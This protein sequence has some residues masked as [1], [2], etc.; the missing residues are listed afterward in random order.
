M[1]TFLAVAL[2]A[3]LFVGMLYL[4]WIETGINDSLKGIDSPLV[5]ESAKLPLPNKVMTVLL[6]P[7]FVLPMLLLAILA[8]MAGRRR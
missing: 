8:A 1:E 5:R 4:W 3:Y 7:L 2:V 6:W